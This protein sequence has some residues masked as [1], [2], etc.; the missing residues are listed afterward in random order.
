MLFHKYISTGLGI[1]YIGKGFG[2]ERYTRLTKE[3]QITMM[4]LWCMF[5][6]PLMIGSE[7]TRLDQW[8]LEL[9]TNQRVLSLLTASEG[10]KQVMRNKQQAI[11][12]SKASNEAAY[13][14]ALFNLS[15]E[16]RNIG[17]TAE[18]LEMESFKD[19]VLEDLWNGEIQKGNDRI[20]ESEVLTHGSKLYKVYHL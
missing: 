1:G 2:E 8:T 12:I 5:R 13:Y 19:Y 11:W 7:L 14:L 17:I 4:T 20:F 10:A 15:D 18:E 16:T 6:S 9:L 3:E